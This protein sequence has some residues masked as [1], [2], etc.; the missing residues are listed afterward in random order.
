MS[1]YTLYTI[2]NQLKKTDNKQGFVAEEDSSEEWKTR[3]VY[4]FW[5][6]SL[7]VRSEYI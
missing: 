2:Y 1:I 7:K 4:C 3:Q 6:S 5:K